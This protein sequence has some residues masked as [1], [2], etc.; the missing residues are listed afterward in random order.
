MNTRQDTW[1]VKRRLSVLSAEKITLQISEIVKSGKGK[2]Y[3]QNK[4]HK[5]FTFPEVR[6]MIEAVNYSEMSKRN[7]LSTNQQGHQTYENNQTGI[8]PEVITQLINEM[9]MLIQEMK[10]IIR[11]VTENKRLSKENS[12]T[13]DSTN[14]E[15]EIN[16]IKQREPKGHLF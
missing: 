4:I 5:N 16:K 12:N 2:R 10:T 14:H 9:R 15:R 11:T 6:K 8:K 7:I 13:K 3:Y 1:T